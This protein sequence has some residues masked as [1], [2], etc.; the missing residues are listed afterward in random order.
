MCGKLPASSA[1][2]LGLLVPPLSREDLLRF[3]RADVNA[4]GPPASRSVPPP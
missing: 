3:A 1:E 4:S 2:H